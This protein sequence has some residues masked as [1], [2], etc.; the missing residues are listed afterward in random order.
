MIYVKLAYGLIMI[1]SIWGEKTAKIV[2]MGMGVVG[3]G[4]EEDR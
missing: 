2:R 3:V 4:W 1:H